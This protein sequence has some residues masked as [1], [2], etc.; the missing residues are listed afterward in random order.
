MADMEVADPS[1][2]ALGLNMVSIAPLTSHRLR[3]PRDADSA[4]IALIAE[5]AINAINETEL[6][7]VL[8]AR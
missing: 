2:R 6:M 7:T 8:I 1:E 3:A 5:S 4:L